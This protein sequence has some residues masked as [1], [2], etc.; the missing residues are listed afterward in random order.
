LYRGEEKGEETEGVKESQGRRGEREGK[1]RERRKK[2]WKSGGGY[3]GA[4]LPTAHLLF[5][6]SELECLY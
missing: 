6:I 4:S 5:L 2:R 1:G 3:L